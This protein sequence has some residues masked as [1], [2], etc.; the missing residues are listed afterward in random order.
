MLSWDIGLVVV[1]PVDLRHR[2]TWFSL[3]PRW[4]SFVQT[5][6]ERL[7]GDFPRGHLWGRYH[8]WK[9]GI[10]MRVPFLHGSLHLPSGADGNRI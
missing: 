4:L 2:R 9:A 3:M 7:S 6:Q 5:P 10:R 8:R 1:L